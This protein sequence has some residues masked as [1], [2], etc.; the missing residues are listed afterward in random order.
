MRKKLEEMG[1][2]PG[3]MMSRMHYFYAVDLLRRGE[4]EKAIARLNRGVAEDSEDVDVL[5]ALFRLPERTAEQQA[6][7][8]RLI[9]QATE[10]SRQTIVEATQALSQ[11]QAIPGQELEFYKRRLAGAHNQFA[12]LVANTEGDF[13]AAVA[14]SHESLKLRPGEGAYLD[15]LG[16]SYFANG[17]LTNAIKYQTEAVRKDPHNGQLKRQL[18]RFKK[19][20]EK[21]Q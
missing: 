13:E 18:E 11:V 17:D 16:A 2:E 19:E 8:R 9:R 4:K 21:R 12:W 6:E 5:I 10:D 7:T 14:S 3:G 1:Y 20:A 15:T